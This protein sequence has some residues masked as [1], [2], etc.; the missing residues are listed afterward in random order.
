VDLN[1]ATH[2]KWPPAAAAVV[3]SSFSHRSPITLLSLFVY[4]STQGGYKA[5]ETGRKF[6]RK[7]VRRTEVVGGWEGRGGRREEGSNGDGKQRR[8]SK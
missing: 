6:T 4:V 3:S 7:I 8:G 1:G 2:Q 5:P